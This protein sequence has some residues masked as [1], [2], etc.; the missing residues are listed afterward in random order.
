MLQRFRNAIPFLLAIWLSASPAWAMNCEKDSLSEVSGSGA[1]LEMLSGQIYKVDEV[2]Q[3][4]SSL[5]LGAEDVL[6][7][8]QVVT[9]KGKQVTIY[10]IIA[11]SDPESQVRC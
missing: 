9:I 3:V 10:S 2:D 7:C 8:T 6:I 4:D 1:I 5:W 11:P